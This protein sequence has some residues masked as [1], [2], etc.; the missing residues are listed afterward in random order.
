MNKEFKQWV[1]DLFSNSEN[2][3]SSRIAFLL[4]IFAVLVLVIFYLLIA[5]K[6][7][8]WNLPETLITNILDKINFLVIGVLSS[9]VITKNVG[10]FLEN[11]K[12]DGE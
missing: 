5:I 10:K 4:L 3:S 11:N 7:T 1:Y 8:V 6:G 12:K 9:A 2:V